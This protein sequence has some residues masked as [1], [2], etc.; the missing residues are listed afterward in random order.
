MALA[1]SASRAV[2]RPYNATTG[3]S[4]ACSRESLRYESRFAVAVGSDKR[5]S[6]SANLN[7]NCVSLADREGFMRYS[8]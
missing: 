3:V 6:I 8:L 4:S 5:A 7:V 1:A 2:K